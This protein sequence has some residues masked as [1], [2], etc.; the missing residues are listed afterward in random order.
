MR[1]IR[2]DMRDKRYIKWRAWDYFK[3][4]IPNKAFFPYSLFLSASLVFLYVYVFPLN[5]LS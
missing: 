5:L 1:S 2:A 4:L 3:S